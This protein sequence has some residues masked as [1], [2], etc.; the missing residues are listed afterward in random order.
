MI[1]HLGVCFP[2]SSSLGL[3]AGG[4]K[5]FMLSPSLRLSCAEGGCKAS[6]AAEERC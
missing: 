5:F 2:F 1:G 4:C 6:W 3:G